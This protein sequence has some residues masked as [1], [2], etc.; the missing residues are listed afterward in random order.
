MSPNQSP[1][2]GD[3]IRIHFESGSG[4]DDQNYKLAVVLSPSI[5]NKKTGLFVCCPI[6][7]QVKGYPFEVIVGPE[8]NLAVLADQ[9]KSLDWAH[10][11]ISHHARV[12]PDELSEIRLKL[13][14]LIFKG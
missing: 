3:I 10:S 13:H 7:P 4:S 6:T 1:T 9:V 14:A 8:R 12:S 11:K 2:V 5:Y